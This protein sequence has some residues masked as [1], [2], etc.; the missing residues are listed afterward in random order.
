MVAR[1]RFPIRLN[2]A[3]AARPQANPLPKHLRDQ[4]LVGADMM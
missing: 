3:P 4:G 1:P 2:E